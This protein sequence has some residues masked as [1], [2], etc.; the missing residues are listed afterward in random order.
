MLF[1]L[2]LGHFARELRHYTSEVLRPLKTATEDHPL[3]K[4]IHARRSSSSHED[5]KTPSSENNY[6]PGVLPAAKEAK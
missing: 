4:Q 1:P 3:K 6:G 2:P 5:D